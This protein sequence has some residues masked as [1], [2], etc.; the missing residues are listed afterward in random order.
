MKRPLDY[1]TRIDMR[2]ELNN[3]FDKYDEV[4]RGYRYQILTGLDKIMKELETMREESTVG[5]H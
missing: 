2:E 4:N 5:A 1:V 3:A